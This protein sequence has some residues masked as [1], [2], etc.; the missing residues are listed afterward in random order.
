[1]GIKLKEIRREQ[2][3]LV[4]NL[5]L[6]GVFS[7]RLKETKLKAY[8]GDN[9]LEIITTDSEL[10]EHNSQLTAQI[11]GENLEI[12]FNQKYLLEGLEP[13][14]SDSVI[15]RFS[16]ASRPLLIQNPRD[17]SYTYLVMP[18]KNS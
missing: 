18:M 17:V 12:S 1:M 9:I 7:G 3:E 4:E 2:K 10:G 6:A 14:A 8:A 5:K 15:L 13:I 16:G 11:T